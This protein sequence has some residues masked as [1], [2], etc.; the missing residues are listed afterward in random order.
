M[1]ILRQVRQLLQDLAH[2]HIAH[3]HPQANY[4]FND[5]P[6]VYRQMFIDLYNAKE[7]ELL[8][9]LT[10]TYSANLLDSLAKLKKMDMTG[11]ELLQ[12]ITSDADPY[13]WYNTIH[14]LL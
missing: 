1:S 11:E 2:E 8:Y 14:T 13:K 4:I 3:E 7:Y 12:F 9:E 5:L 6:Y 10:F